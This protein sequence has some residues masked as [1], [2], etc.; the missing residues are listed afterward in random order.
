[1]IIKYF[2][3]ASGAKRLTRAARGQHHIAQMRQP[4]PAETSHTKER[5][6]ASSVRKQADKAALAE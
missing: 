2:L 3:D 5:F 4:L 6:Q 1:L